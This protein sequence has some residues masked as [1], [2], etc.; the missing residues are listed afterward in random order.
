[1]GILTAYH[2][3]VAYFE[4]RANWRIHLLQQTNKNRLFVDVLNKMFWRTAINSSTSAYSNRYRYSGLTESQRVFYSKFLR[5]HD[6]A[7]EIPLIWQLHYDRETE[8][9][10]NVISSS[11]SFLNQHCYSGLNRLR[12]TVCLVR[13][14]WTLCTYSKRKLEKLFIEN[15]RC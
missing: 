5:R 6:H 8:I 14:A 10:P 15:E 2:K 9:K 11:P 3:N 7:N 1:M 13:P 4:Y 12:R